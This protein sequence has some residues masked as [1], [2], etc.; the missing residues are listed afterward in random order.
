MTL[1]CSGGQWGHCNGAAKGGCACLWA[2]IS[3][4]AISCRPD[5]AQECDR[6]P[7]ASAPSTAHTAQRATSALQPGGRTWPSLLLPVLP[8]PLLK[9]PVL[10]CSTQMEAG[11]NCH[12]AGAAIG[13]ACS[14]RTA[15][16]HQKAPPSWQEGAHILELHPRARPALS[17]GPGCHCPHC[18]R[19]PQ[20]SRCPRSSSQRCSRGIGLLE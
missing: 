18:Q 10:P 8:W 13:H 16:P 17:P 14:W 19:S 5:R 4:D 1:V 2:Y 7:Q 3:G 12:Q 11:Q 15:R 6:L 9:L 20:R